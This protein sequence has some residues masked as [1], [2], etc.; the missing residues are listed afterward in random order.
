LVKPLGNALEVHLNRE[1]AR[2]VR[3]D[4]GWRIHCRDHEGGELFDVAVCTAPAPQAAAL[5]RHETGIAEGLAKVSIAPCWALMVSFAARF[6]PGF[7]AHRFD[8]GALAWVARNSSKPGRHTET[9]C[10][11][12]HAAPDWS[13]EH[14]EKSRDEIAPLMI[15]MIEGLSDGPL[16]EIGHASAHRWRYALTTEPL[17]T[18]F[19]CSADRSLFLGGD[20]CLG[21]RVEYA[22]TSGRQMAH[23]VLESRKG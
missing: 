13:Q 14:L 1:V 15:E 8:R 17:G 12:L 5:F 19:I 23:A 7:E 22:F 2:V 18:P 20:W 16:P 10:W 3:D 9:D 11:V 21:A 4:G 6:D